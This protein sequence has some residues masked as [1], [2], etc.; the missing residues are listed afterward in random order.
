MPCRPSTRPGSYIN[1]TPYPPTPSPSPTSKCPQALRLQ[2]TATPRG[3]WRHNVTE[4]SPPIRSQTNGTG[5]VAV[6]V[7]VAK[8]KGESCIVLM[9]GRCAWWCNII[10]AAPQNKLIC[11]GFRMHSMLAQTLFMRHRVWGCPLFAYVVLHA[12]SGP[13]SAFFVCM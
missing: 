4:V 2:R 6:I 10:L 9:L 3:L 13:P 1:H 11:V 8:M 7:L 5:N 12:I